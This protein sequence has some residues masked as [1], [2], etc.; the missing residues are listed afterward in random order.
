M[1]RMLWVAA[2]V[3]S[4]IYGAVKVRRATEIFTPD[5]ARDRWHALSHGARMLA[6]DVH[7]AHHA[8]RT[9]LRQRYGLAAL[10]T[11]RTPELEESHSE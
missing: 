9:E 11:P 10:A 3:T 6:L 5:G 4:T 2:G 7:T 1:S 8:R